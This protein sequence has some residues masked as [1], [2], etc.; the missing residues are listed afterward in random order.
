MSNDTLIII[1]AIITLAFGL[2]WGVWQIM[3]TRR[4]NAEGTKSAMTKSVEEHGA[5]R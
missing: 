5:R 2:G 1:L 4:A 3:K